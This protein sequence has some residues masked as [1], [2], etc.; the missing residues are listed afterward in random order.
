MSLETFSNNGCEGLCEEEVP[1]G[2]DPRFFSSSISPMSA[3]ASRSCSRCSSS[4]QRD[5]GLIQSDQTKSAT[6]NRGGAEGDTRGSASWRSTYAGGPRSASLLGLPEPAI[7]PPGSKQAAQSILTTLQ[8]TD[9]AEVFQPR[10]IVSFRRG[11]RAIDPRIPRSRR[12]RRI[13]R[14]HPGRHQSRSKSEFL[15]RFFQIHNGP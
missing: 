1:N 14:F 5:P 4:C 10:V 7:Q 2:G 3:A 12:P 15:P 8:K 9:L 6:P 11:T 13:G